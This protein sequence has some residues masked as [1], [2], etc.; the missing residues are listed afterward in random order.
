MCGIIA[1]VG[2]HRYDKVPDSLIDRGVDD[3]GIYSDDNVQL[4]QT[5]LQITGKDVFNLPVQNDRYVILFN[6]EVYN[7]IELRKL[8][9]NN[10]MLC[11]F[12]RCIYSQN[13]R[14]HN[15]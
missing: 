3:H 15:R 4:I 12:S 5:R 14:T 9:E 13:Y 7:Y 6:G 10:L 11:T 2:K 8:L 1:V